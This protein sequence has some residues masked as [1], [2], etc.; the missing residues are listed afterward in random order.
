MEQITSIIYFFCTYGNTPMIF[1]LILL[2]SGLH[3][4][5]FKCLT[6]YSCYK[7][8]LVMMCYSSYISRDL[9][10]KYLDYGFYIFV[11]ESYWP[12]I[13]LSYTILFR[14]YYWGYS[15]LSTWC[16]QCLTLFL[17]SYHVSLLLFPFYSWAY[18]T[19]EAIWNRNLLWGKKLNN[20]LNFFNI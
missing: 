7:S 19:R 2:Q 20:W 9:N 10:F 4:L 1:S 6:L 16:R 14:F 3:W 12:V 11:H 5:I 18:F 8:Y 13:F 15:C 17:F